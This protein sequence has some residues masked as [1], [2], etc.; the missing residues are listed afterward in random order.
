MSDSKMTA[1]VTPSLRLSWLPVR[2][3]H[4]RV[5]MEAHWTAGPVVPR[6]R[7]AA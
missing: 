2:D 3:A 5:R 1:A 7:S 6:V 4:G